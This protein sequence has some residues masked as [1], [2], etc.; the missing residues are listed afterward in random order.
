M[1]LLARRNFR[2]FTTSKLSCSKPR[3]R[4]KNFLLDQDPYNAFDSGSNNLENP[5]QPLESKQRHGSVSTIVLKQP[6]KREHVSDDEAYEIIE[7][8]SEI[9]IN[10][11]PGLET[12]LAANS[13]DESELPSLSTQS[14]VFT[15]TERSNP[16]P[17]R[18]KP[19]LPNEFI[20]RFPECTTSASYD[21]EG[22]PGRGIYCGRHK[23]LFMVSSIERC[24]V[25]SCK[26]SRWYSFPGKPHSQAVCESHREEGMI[27]VKKR[28]CES[29]G[30]R[31][32]PSFGMHSGAPARFCKQH[33]VQG[34]V[35]ILE[36]PRV[37]W[38]NVEQQRPGDHPGRR[39]RPDKLCQ[40]PECTKRA[41]YFHEGGHSTKPT[42]CGTHREFGMV[43]YQ[44]RCCVKGCTR[45]GWFKPAHGSQQQE[46]RCL[47]HTRP[48][49]IP[50]ERRRCEV[51]G[52]AEAPTHATE[53]GLPA[54]FCR[55][56]AQPELFILG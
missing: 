26:Y 7:W 8:G 22:E 23:Q 6:L 46:G 5:S 12:A 9:A 24:A 40:Y 18:K 44:G 13:L 53:R 48:G 45:F 15:R 11:D 41:N 54:R 2:V 10:S 25:K 31:Q 38:N 33:R 50:V 4:M 32:V 37:D 27:P 20:C 19:N 49:M 30:C 17:K 16:S 3:N 56:H 28:F 14:S 1:K 52:C 29:A 42:R 55:E 39:F 21:F 47:V 36:A 34:T 43:E 35:E 51:P